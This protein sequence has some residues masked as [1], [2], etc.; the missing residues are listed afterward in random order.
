VVRGHGE[1]DPGVDAR[2]LLHHDRVVE[3]AQPRPSV[4]G[5]PHDTHEAHLT[6]LG[7]HLAGELLLLVPL[8]GM[9]RKLALRELAHRLLEELLL[10]AQAEVQALDDTCGR[11]G[12]ATRGAPP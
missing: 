9:R 6:E 4:F 1:R 2:E 8:A 7:E 10:L 3:R 5:R 12:W 11:P